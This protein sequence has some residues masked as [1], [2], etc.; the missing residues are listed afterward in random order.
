MR[1]NILLTLIALTSLPVLAGELPPA[2]EADRQAILA[3]AGKFKVHFQFN[4][5]LAFR[6]GYELTKPMNED[7]HEWVVVA[8]DTPRR[9]EL[10]HLLI[11]GNGPMVVHHWRQIWTYED[12]RVNE[13]QGENNWKTRE[14]T[15]E[16][17]KGTWTQLVTQ[18][19]N[20]PRYESWGRWNHEGNAD[21]WV[22]GD[23]WRPL[24]RREH[25]KR[26]DYDVLSGIN[27][28]VITP[29]GWAH[30]QT[31][32]KLDLTP[33]GPKAIARELGLN[34]YTKD[35]SFDY[36][37]AEKYWEGYRDFSNA[38]AEEWEQVI[39]RENAYRIEDDIE[40]SELRDAMKDIAREKLPIAEARPKIKAAIEK[41]LR[42]PGATAAAEAK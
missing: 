20:S 24:P 15:P 40:V 30:E 11:V 29:T 32:T 7:T 18:V 37:A 42:Q 38:L 12:T 25:T 22:S 2:P 10:Q 1:T 13:F 36:S 3:M 39:A 8:K 41:L 17:A 9:I 23:T 27:I 31:N 16:Q 14:L 4:E 19:D 5:T 33:A 21:R 26:K 6:P 35:E 28:H 34:T